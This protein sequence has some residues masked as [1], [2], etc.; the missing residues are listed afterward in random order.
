MFSW[1]AN[2]LPPGRS[3][4]L[5]ARCGTWL[6][7]SL[8]SEVLQCGRVVIPAFICLERQALSLR[9]AEN[10]SVLIPVWQTKLSSRASACD[11]GRDGCLQEGA[12]PSHPRLVFPCRPWCSRHSK[13]PS[14]ALSLQGFLQCQLSERPAE[15][16]QINA[17]VGL[18]ANGLSGVFGT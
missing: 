18:P 10:Q 11:C 14:S 1:V 15:K 4:R 17:V 9:P 12:R 5:L 8:L 7:K 13:H 3:L 6:L 16:Q 2:S